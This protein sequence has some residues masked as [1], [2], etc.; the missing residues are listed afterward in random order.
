MLRQMDSVL[1]LDNFLC[2]RSVREVPMNKFVHAAM[3]T[4]LVFTAGAPNKALA[5]APAPVPVPTPIVAKALNVSAGAS[6][7]A[8]AAATGG[9][10]GFV[11]LLVTYD[12]IRRT[13][14]SGDFLH[15][16]G[17][18]FSTPITP[19]MSIISPPKCAPAL[20]HSPVLHAKG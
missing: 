16:G 3:A 20:K 15:L 11:A 13:S 5:L 17:P 6:S 2:V 18:G 8:G 10:I 19:G 4:A 7:T 14:C 12:I 9:F 1:T